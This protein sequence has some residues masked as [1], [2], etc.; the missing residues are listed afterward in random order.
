MPL[1]HH[2][3]P[4]AADPLAESTVFHPDPELSEQ[5]SRMTAQALSEVAV[6]GAV[7]S[8]RSRVSELEQ[9]VALLRAE[10]QWREAGWSEERG[11]LQS[12][13]HTAQL[14]TTELRTRLE[15][16]HLDIMEMED[17]LTC[18]R[19]A[20]Q[21]ERLALAAVT[22]QGETQREQLAAFE[23]ELTTLRTQLMERERVL[24]AMWQTL[25]EYR[26]QGPLHRLLRRPGLP[27]QE[28]P[29]LIGTVEAE[30]AAD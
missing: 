13:I 25:Q 18:S 28:A 30:S 20:L 24:G 29:R 15:Q 23:A 19:A 26:A 11:E 6:S 21:S 27:D 14:D 3:S 12:E 7:Q 2:A 10:A 5:I 4:V 16:S 9:E 17:E 1:T 8:A 22:A